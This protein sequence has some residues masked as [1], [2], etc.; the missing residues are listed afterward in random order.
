[1]FFIKEVQANG[2]RQ[3]GW[4][5]HRYKHALSCTHTNTQKHTHTHTYG[6]PHTHTHQTHAHGPAYY[7][8]QRDAALH[9]ISHRETQLYTGVHDSRRATLRKPRCMQAHKH[10]HGHTETREN[11]TTLA[12]CEACCMPCQHILRGQCPEASSCPLV[13]Q[14]C[15]RQQGFFGKA[16]VGLPHKRTPKYTDGH[17]HTHRHRRKHRHTHTL[18]NVRLID[19]SAGG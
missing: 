6:R 5:Q 16:Q 15:A 14:Q 8:P 13:K 19:T 12:S 11:V 7:F 17:T 18:V 10:K 3:R 9:N 2:H 4:T 1:M